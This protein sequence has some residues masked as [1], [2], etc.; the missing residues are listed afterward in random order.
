MLRLHSG[1]SCCVAPGVPEE[2]EEEEEESC[3]RSLGGE[4]G[5]LLLT[6]LWK[7][8]YLYRYYSAITA[9][10]QLILARPAITA[11]QHI[12]YSATTYL[13]Q[14][15]YSAL[16]TK[17]RPTWGSVLGLAILSLSFRVWIDYSGHPCAC[18]AT[19]M[20]IKCRTH[21]AERGRQTDGRETDMSL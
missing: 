5:R 1:V 2:D 19:R 17:T 20:L 8:E 16:A 9:Q 4:D 12:Y 10:F 21:G 6:R 11:L 3:S 7:S 14:R 18:L 15:Y 13:V